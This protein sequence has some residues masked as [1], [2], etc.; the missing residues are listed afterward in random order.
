[1]KK[2]L[3][4]GSLVLSMSYVNS[5]YAVDPVTTG[6]TT[7]G[8]VAMADGAAGTAAILGAGAATAIGSTVVGVGAGFATAEIMNNELF[9]NCPT[10]QTACDAAKVGTYSGAGIGT[11]GVLGTLAA[12]GAD[13]AGL[14]AIGGAVGG[15]VAMGVTTLV[16]APIVAA[17]VVGYATY[18]WYD[19]K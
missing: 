4:A 7:G 14:A 13:T 3:I 19:R 16:A 18:W 10:N 8:A 6:T 1:M 17:A 15:G 11:L 2:W 9:A 12:V 5:A